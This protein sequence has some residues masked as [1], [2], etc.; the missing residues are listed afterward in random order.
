ML[1][2]KIERRQVIALVGSAAVGWPLALRAQQAE[3]MRRVA[4]LLPFTDTDAEVQ[5]WITALRQGLRELG[6]TDGGNIRIETY[7]GAADIGRISR[8]AAELIEHKPDVVIANGPLAVTA[9]KQ[10]AGKTPIVFL[11][12]VDP[13]ASGFAASLARPGGNVTGF[14]LGEFAM[15][16]KALEIL[17]QI[18][19]AI[20]RVV[21]IYNPQQV[22]QVGRLASITAVAPS[23]GLQVTGASAGDAER[24]NQIIEDLGAEPSTGVVVLGNPVTIVNRAVIIALLARYRLPA[25]YD[26]PFFARD[27]GLISYG[28]DASAQFRQAASYID[29]ILKGTR[30]ADLPIQ[31]PTKF[32]LVINL[33]TAKAL[34]LT[35]SPSLLASADELIE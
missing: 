34:G 35:A 19:P 30:A 16:G 25:V 22:P 1:S 6:W 12:V 26:Y 31:Q 17:K 2:G 5:R 32:V 27:G 8:A 13:V 3:G 9:L 15:S 14:T 20:S 21:V 28:I 11:G 24:I 7:W 33:K 23:L 10:V 4:I 29:R 18:A